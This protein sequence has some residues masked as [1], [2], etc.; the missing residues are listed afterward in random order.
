M[1]FSLASIFIFAVLSILI[2]APLGASDIALIWVIK[3]FCWNKKFVL[4][5]Q[6][7]WYTFKLGSSEN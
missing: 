1:L 6:F 2:T 3:D 5:I 7:L 4:K